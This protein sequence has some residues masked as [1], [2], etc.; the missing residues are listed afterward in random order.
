[1]AQ[2]AVND[3]PTG[4]VSGCLGQDAVAQHGHAHIDHAKDEPQEQQEDQAGLDQ[5]SSSPL[6]ALSS[7]HGSRPPIRCPYDTPRM[8]T[9]RLRVRLE[10]TPGQ[11]TTVWN[12]QVTVTTTRQ[13][14]LVS[15]T[16]VTV[17]LLALKPET[18]PISFT[19]ACWTWVA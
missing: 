16:V 1:R 10:G 19:A 11:R 13:S 5:A 17:T 7:H 14:P 6:L 4:T 12:G 9:V 15:V 3:C 8:I 18:D 2:L